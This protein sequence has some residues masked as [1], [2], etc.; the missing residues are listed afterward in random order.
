M[1]NCMY[2]PHFDLLTLFLYVFV[3]LF[4][5]FYVKQVK[6]GY[7]FN[8]D[9]VKFP[10][11]LYD[12]AFIFFLVIFAV[13]R[14]VAYGIGG[15]DALNYKIIFENILFDSNRFLEQEQL[16]LFINILVRSFTD[17][18]IV[19]FALCYGIIAL[20]YVLFIKEFAPKV[21]SF[22]PF[23][24]LVFPYLRSF[25]TM[26]S[27]IAIAVFLIGL[28]LL[29]RKKTKW[30]IIILLSTFFIHRMSILY[31]A[32]LPFYFFS[33]KF[34][35]L[36]NNR[37]Y[38]GLFIYI[39]LA[40]LFALHMQDYMSVSDLVNEQDLYYVSASRGENLFQRWPMLF[41]H[42]VLLLFLFKYNK[43]VLETYNCRMLMLL[44]IFDIIVMPS[45]LVLNMWRATE[46]LYVAR[47]IMWGMII[48]ILLKN[49]HGFQKN[50][51]HLV[52]LIVFA[53]WLVFRICSEWD[54]AKLMPYILNWF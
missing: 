20:G 43:K 5:M 10:I 2:S 21:I 28:V 31:I 3:G 46:Y 23:I 40:Y 19:Y 34:D 13:S 11:R 25:N 35:I 51:I 50:I 1:V 15:Q 41:P 44:C 16:F 52:S 9:T 14:E 17:N 37:L 26:R 42:I 8:R 48:H 36:K 38:W 24:L 12:V 49:I 22:T 6:F 30:A 27:S 4:C 39:P 7:V 33:Q 29:N 53:S 54:D 47:L 45:S 32:F 18:Y